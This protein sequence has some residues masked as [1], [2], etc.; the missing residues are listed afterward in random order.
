MLKQKGYV[1]IDYLKPAAELTRPAKAGSY[2]RMNLRSGQ[3]G[4][5]VGCGPATDTLILAR[6]LE[7]D[8]RVVGVDFDADMIAPTE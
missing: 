4:L 2:A 5:D 1:N 6:L 7:P 8:G 3:R